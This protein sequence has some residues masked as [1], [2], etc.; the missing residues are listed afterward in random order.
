M[1][2]TN[3]EISLLNR[4][5]VVA[6]F[7]SPDGRSIA[8]FVPEVLQDGDINA[9]R[10]ELKEDVSAKPNQQLNLPTLRLIVFDIET[11]EGTSLLTFTSTL[12]F[13]TQ[14]VPFFDQYAFSHRL[15][16][17]TSDALVLP[18]LEDGRSQIYIIPTQGGQKR[19][20]AEGSMPSWSQQ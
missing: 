20:L 2:T 9:V 13:L 16:S 8:A 12:T 6:F 5:P 4:S 17:P 19:H 11:G 18:V 10:P 14:F 15:W 1:N 3:G 7:W